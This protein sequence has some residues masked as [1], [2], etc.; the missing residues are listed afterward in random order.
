[1]SLPVLR[2]HLRTICHTLSPYHF[3]LSTPPPMSLSDLNCRPPVTACPQ[4]SDCHYLPSTI[5]LSLPPITLCPLRFPCHCLPSTVP[6]SLVALHC[7]LSSPA[8]HYPLSHPALYNSTVTTCYL[9]PHVTTFPT[10]SPCHCLLSTA[11]PPFQNL[12][13]NV[14]QSQPA[15]HGPHVNAC[16]PLPPCLNLHSTVPLSL[17]ALHCPPVI[18]CPKLSPCHCPLITACPPLFP[19]HNLP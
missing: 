1:M 12:P 13:S 15:L 7:T 10:L 19:C 2:C 6:L 11:L 4:L 9:L 14:P 18:T 5:P 3:L 17:S 16:P 8:L